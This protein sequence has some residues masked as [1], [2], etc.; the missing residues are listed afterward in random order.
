[1]AFPRGGGS[2]LDQLTG[3]VTAG[4]G[5]GSQAA[6]LATVS[7]AQ[8][9]GDASHY[10]IVTTDAKG[11]VTAMTAQAVPLSSLSS[12]SG[13]LGA[14]VT[15]AQNTAT[16]VMSTASLAVGTWLVN[17]G[18]TVDIVAAGTEI[19]FYPTLGTATAT[20]SGPVV[21]QAGYTTSIGAGA[22]PTVGLS[23]IVT[24]TVAGTIN[25]TGEMVGS[26]TSSTV[27]ASSNQSR[28]GATGYAAVK[29]A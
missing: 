11:R 28:A 22:E 16:T 25:L 14:N 1:M 21:A 19:D 4:P 23:L 5:T 7:T 9:V 8:T 17:F 26:N 24:V 2:G 6:T 3:D 10:P 20:F 29:I 12:S 18:V 13:V 15:L 27:L